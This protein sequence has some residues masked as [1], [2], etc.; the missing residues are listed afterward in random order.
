MLVTGTTA[1]TEDTHRQ[2]G[3]VGPWPKNTADSR[4][5]QG[6]AEGREGISWERIVEGEVVSMIVSI[7]SE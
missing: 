4:E 3:G 5:G 6:L 1:E 7:I 2:V